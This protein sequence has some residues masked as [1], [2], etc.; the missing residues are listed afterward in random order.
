VR[1]ISEPYLIPRDI[2]SKPVLSPVILVTGKLFVIEFLFLITKKKRWIIVELLKFKCV[3][4]SC[5]VDG[6]SASC[7]HWL[8]IKYVLKISL[9]KS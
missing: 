6:Y 1:V 2:G 4:E 5:A 7:T 8:R 3:H 9:W